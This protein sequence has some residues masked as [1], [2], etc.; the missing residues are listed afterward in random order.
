MSRHH[1]G[2]EHAAASTIYFA[3]AYAVKNQKL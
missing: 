3:A 2:L 1:A